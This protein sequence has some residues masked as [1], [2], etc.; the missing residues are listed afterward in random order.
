LGILFSSIL[1]T[2][3]N[4]RNLFNLIVLVGFLTNAYISLLVNIFQFSFSLSYTGPK[5]LLYTFL[6]KKFICFLSL[7]VSMQVFEAYVKV[8]SIIV[9]YSLNFS[10]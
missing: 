4:Q 8:L 10:F 6:S 7:F 9:F 5:I 3:P 1:C 2:C